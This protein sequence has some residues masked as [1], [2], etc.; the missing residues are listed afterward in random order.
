MEQIKKRRS[1]FDLILKYLL[2]ISTAFFLSLIL[3]TF[4]FIK[5]FKSYVEERQKGYQ[6]VFANSIRNDIH[7]GV[8]YN[9][10]R[11]CQN[12]FNDPDIVSIKVIDIFNKT[13]CNLNKLTEVNF[14]WSIPIYFDSNNKEIAAHV[15][16]E[17]SNLLIQKG[18]R[19][20]LI[21]TFIIIIF[22]VLLVLYLKEN[23]D[24]QVS[25]P[26][27]I[28]SFQMK[29]YGDS[30]KNP[31]LN[32]TIHLNNID[33]LILININFKNMIQ[34]LNSY[35]EQL[36]LLAKEQGKYELSL[37]ISH[38][39]RSPLSVIELLTT[40]LSEL[41]D[42][43]RIILRSAAN[44]I[45]DIANQL[46]LSS[47]Y[48]NK[49]IVKNDFIDIYEN[50]LSIEL[51]PLIVDDLISE[52]RV[53]Y[54]SSENIIIDV[55]FTDAFGA[56]AK[57]N[58]VELKI[59]LS[60]L[61]NNSVEAIENNSGKIVVC[62][63]NYTSKKIIIIRDNGRGIPD[64]I[65]EKLGS[66][67]ITYGK[68]SSTTGSG[69]GLGIFHAKSTIESFNGKFY[70]QSKIGF[71]TEIRIEFP[72]CDEP[73]WFVSK[74][75]LRNISY[76]IAIDDDPIILDLWDQKIRNYINENQKS[77]NFKLITFSEVQ[78][79]INWYEK[80]DKIETPNNSIIYLFDY[81]FKLNEETG[82]DIIR[83]FNLNHKHEQT[84]I[85]T[86]RY[87]DVN[88]RNGCEQIGLKLISK[89]LIGYLPIEY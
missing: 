55:D 81:E 76:I 75:D 5:E 15:E 78:S 8:E 67:G 66:K 24:K 70:I 57:I 2:L 7:T 42:E 31:P 83:K 69:N 19:R 27:K 43:K 61:I 50:N 73:S 6:L 54:R 47:N 38:D 13:Y 74:L 36:K 59:L 35:E 79:F 21:F 17:Y 4:V 11:K 23:L 44:R 56:F 9:V 45:K 84:Y 37:Q 87:D 88:L 39:I 64:H 30:K 41:T 22:L 28:L 10:Y 34:Q 33:E 51:L 80:F 40:N 14:K 16:V 85:L 29:E 25:N 60:N 82:L 62:V 32:S 58:T 86:N 20:N 77:F 18:V 71:G 48:K 68:E 65:V 49:V 53:Q 72:A 63:K 46:L 89:S 3:F 1:I 52:K 26:L 12:F